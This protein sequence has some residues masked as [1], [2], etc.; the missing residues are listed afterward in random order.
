MDDAIFIMFSSSFILSAS[1]ES[2]KN[3]KQ[4]ELMLGKI[5]FQ[6]E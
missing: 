2:L 3:A 5:G 4:I 6:E 1:I